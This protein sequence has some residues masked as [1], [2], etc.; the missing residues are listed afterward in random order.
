M[1]KT[2]VRIAREKEKVVG[3]CIHVEGVRNATVRG[4]NR[5]DIDGHCISVSKDIKAGKRN[6]V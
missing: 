5:R 4:K 6:I 2:N 3:L 1:N